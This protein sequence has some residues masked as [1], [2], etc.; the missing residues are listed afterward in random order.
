MGWDDFV[1]NM[2]L[3]ALFL[4]LK[5]PAKL[6]GLKKAMLKLRNAI[7]LAYASDPDFQ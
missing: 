7:N 3:S 1:I 5:N 4:A 2:G 6:A